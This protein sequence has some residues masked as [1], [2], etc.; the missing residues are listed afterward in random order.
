MIDMSVRG[1]R[2]IRLKIAGERL[3]NG[4]V[5]KGKERT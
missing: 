2:I 1:K 4:V 5:C 3:R